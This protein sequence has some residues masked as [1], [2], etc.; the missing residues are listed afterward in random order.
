MYKKA[1]CKECSD[2][3]VKPVI[4]GLCQYH[5]RLERAKVYQ[6][7]KKIK[8]RKAT[9]EMKMF[10]EIF[11][12]RPSYCFITD[13]FLGTKTFLKQTRQFHHLFHHVLRK[14]AYPSFRLYKNNIIMVTKEVH[15][16]IETKAMSDLLKEDFRY[17]R[18][19]ELH[20][21]LKQEYYAKNIFI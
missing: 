19:K 7:R 10:D 8:P 21:K 2:E 17:E 3:T 20:E 13:V 14:S 12:E 15:H 4:K 6:G 11:D 16:K 1:K 18:L 5:Y 9:G